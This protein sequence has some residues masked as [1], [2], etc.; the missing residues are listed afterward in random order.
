M[1]ETYK[2][3]RWN[4]FNRAIDHYLWV[5]IAT[6][7]VIFT[8]SSF[9][10]TPSISLSILLIR[11]LG[12]SAFLLLHIILSIGPLCRLNPRFLPM[13]YNRRH[14]GVACFILALCHGVLVV[15]TYH[16][17]SSM[18]PI[19]S[20]FASDAGSTIGAVPFQTFGA[21]AL[22][23]LF[24]MA[25][26]SHDFWLRHLTP[27]VWKTLHML[28]Y[29]AYGLLVAHVVYGILQSERHPVFLILVFAGAVLVSLLH[30]IAAIREFVGGFHARMN[31]EDDYVETFSVD[32]IPE[33]C[34]KT[35]MLHGERVAVFRYDGKISAI[36]NVCQHQNGPLG[37]GRI[38][39]GCVV[40]PWHGLRYR[41]Q[42]G[43]AQEPGN[44]KVPTFEVKI[45]NGKVWINH[46][47]RLPGSFVEPALIPG[48]HDQTTAT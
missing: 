39:H 28:V 1:S 20:V 47:P 2:A 30:F 40:C 25:A 43:C 11:A 32:E 26:T 44:E 14:M 33:N 24:L 4:R 46:K 38:V 16:V 5:G 13:L 8:L 21:I 31:S 23:I 15:F 3:V 17:G 27:P 7:L 41:P 42:D 9:V 45:I 34:A 10:F 22:V 29:I 35:V 48:N 6:Y 19:V 12:T 36:S 37:E 18:H